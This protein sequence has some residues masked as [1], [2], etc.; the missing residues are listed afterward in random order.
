MNIEGLIWK[1]I[2][3][4]YKIQELVLGIDLY[5]YLIKIERARRNI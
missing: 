5:D 2:K 1:V 4:A 3:E